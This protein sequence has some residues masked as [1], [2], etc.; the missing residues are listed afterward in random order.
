MRRRFTILFTM[1]PMVALSIA[2]SAQLPMD[3][4]FTY[5]GMLKQSGGPVS[6]SCDFQFALYDAPINGHQVG[7]AQTKTGI[8]VSNGLFTVPLSFGTVFHGDSTWLEIQARCPTGIGS[9]ATMTPRQQL[10]A[11]PYALALPGLHT[12]T[13]LWSPN[14]IGG[15][16]G[17]V[18]TAGVVG[19]TISGGGSASGCGNQEKDP[20]PN[21]V[22]DYYGTVGGGAGNQAGDNAGALDDQQFTTI[23]GGLKNTASGYFATVGGGFSNTAGGASAT[24]GG[25]F[26]NTAGPYAAVGGGD[27]NTASGSSSMVPGG[28]SNAAQGDFSFAA[29]YGAHTAPSA[30]GSFVW[31]DISSNFDTMAWGANQFVVRATGGFWLA[32]GVDTQGNFTSGQRMAA[33][34]SSWSPLSDRNAKT[35]M[36]PVDGRV[37]AARL[38]HLPLTTWRYKSQAEGI[39]HMGPVAQD[40][41]AAFGLGEDDRFISTID[42]DGVALAA[43]QGLYREI[44]DRDAKIASLE[45]RLTELEQVLNRQGS[46]A[47]VK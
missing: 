14:I 27:S 43:I 12:E 41:Y 32:T 46:A 3:S 33:G 4:T 30:A 36:M 7:T 5:Q 26:Q 2:I 8:T 47:A 42:A 35:D 19:A 39:R 31:S 16:S 1:A 10:T 15:K 13:N 28:K 11:S 23:G 17:N 34:S 38:S 22:T 29:G 21:R 18:V 20:C 37:I 6:N 25:G 44:Q 45:A 40:F 9:Y 24:V